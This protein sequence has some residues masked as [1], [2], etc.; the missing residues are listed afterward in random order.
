MKI[1]VIGG[2]IGGLSA[3][4]AL[5]AAGMQVEVYE[6]ARELREVGAGLRITPNATRILHRWGLADD[7]AA[8]GT[9]TQHIHYR[10][11]EDG[12]T[13][14]RQQ[15]GQ[16]VEERFGAPYYHFHRSDLLA[17]LIKAVPAEIVH[18]GHKCASIDIGEDGVSVAFQDGK[19]LRADVVVGADG[20]H[21][22]ARRTLHGPDAPRFSGDVSFRGLVPAARMPELVASLT[23]NIWLGGNQH[24]VQTYAGPRYVNFI[25]LVPGE[26]SE[27]SWSAKGDRGELR[28]MFDGWHGLIHEMIDAAD[29]IMRWP[30]Y[31]RDP[32]EIWGKGRVTLLG[33]AAHPMLPYLAQGA[34]QSIEDAALLARCLAGKAAAEA[35]PALREY[36]RLRSP[37]TSKIQVGARREGNIYHLPDGEEQRKRDAEFESIVGANAQRDEWLFGYDVLADYEHTRKQWA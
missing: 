31:D 14:T 8:V 4:V 15:L 9:R 24:F 1:L 29:A 20:M 26:A 22:I 28:R 37:R 19:T 11:W 36:E 6:Q 23:Q 7:L 35:A 34:V 27:E 3:A 16:R 2:G 17:A 5:R 25:A 13:L 32:I 18:L 21:S 30:L 33:D 10:R 12:R